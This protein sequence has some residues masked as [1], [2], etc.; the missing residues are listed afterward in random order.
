M[1]SAGHKVAAKAPISSA[2]FL[3]V[4]DVQDNPRSS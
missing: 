3:R 1:D 4:A 2:L